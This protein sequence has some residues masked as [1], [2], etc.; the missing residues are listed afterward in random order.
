MRST[1]ILKIKQSVFTGGVIYKSKKRLFKVFPQIFERF[2]TAFEY[3][4]TL[5]ERFPEFKL[6][7]ENSDK[8][9]G[10][11]DIFI[12]ALFYLNK[13][14]LNK[15]LETLALKLREDNWTLPERLKMPQ[16]LA[17]YVRAIDIKGFSGLSSY[18]GVE[19]ALETLLSPSPNPSL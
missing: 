9:Y 6:A 4:K 8:R 7:M 16:W 2:P 14:S 13:N 19:R 10:T 11:D 15:E 18:T 3:F 12:K 5:L 1:N 17:D